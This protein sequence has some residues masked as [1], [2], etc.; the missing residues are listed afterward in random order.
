MNVQQQ[1]F[2]ASRNTWITAT[3]LQ[4]P[5]LLALPPWLLC[6]SGCSAAL[7]AL[8]LYQTFLPPSGGSPAGPKGQPF[9]GWLTL[10]PYSYQAASAAF[11]ARPLKRPTSDVFR[12]LT[13]RKTAGLKVWIID[14]DGNKIELWEPKIWDDKNKK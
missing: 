5:A 4:T 3:S 6:R 11:M 2:A 9:Y 1:A 13:S 8:P 14:P 12:L 7:L 10:L